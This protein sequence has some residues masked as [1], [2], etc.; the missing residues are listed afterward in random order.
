M[1]GRRLEVH[2]TPRATY[3]ASLMSEVTFPTSAYSST[4]PKPNKA[5]IVPS[6]WENFTALLNEFEDK[7]EEAKDDLLFWG[8]GN[9]FT[10]VLV[11]QL[12]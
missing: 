2:P 11:N 8:K 4:T 9:F 3:R 10:H 5:P 1:T 12:R 6:L 7:L